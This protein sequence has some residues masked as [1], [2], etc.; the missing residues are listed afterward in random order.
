MP[1]GQVII[2]EINCQ[3]GSYDDSNIDYCIGHAGTS[4][5]GMTKGNPAASCRE[6]ASSKN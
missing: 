6:F 2:I 1:Q 4:L 5:A 3:N